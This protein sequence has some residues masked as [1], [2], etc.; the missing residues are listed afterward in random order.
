MLP[1]QQALLM[2]DTL[3]ADPYWS[4]VVSLLHFDGA[5]GSATFTDAKGKVWTRPG[6]STISTAEKKFGT[7]SLDVVNDSGGGIQTVDSADWHFGSGDFTIECFIYE[8]AVTNWFGSGGYYFGSYLSGVQGYTPWTIYRNGAGIGVSVSQTNVGW[9][10][11]TSGGTLNINT[12]A[13]IAVVR[14]GS[15]LRLFL[16]GVQ[17]GTTGTITGSLFDTQGGCQ[18][19]RIDIP[20]GGQYVLDGYVDEFRATKG[21]ARYTTNFTPPTAPFPNS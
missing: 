3:A 1:I 2:A 10:W 20:S 9:L 6:T 13:H 5:N 12:W 7:G 21:V 18:I 17:V 8:R 19:G 16:D 11:S 14:H 4:N 15:N